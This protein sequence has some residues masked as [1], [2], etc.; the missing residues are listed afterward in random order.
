MKKRIFF[1]A[2]MAAVLVGGCCLL[3]SCEEPVSGKIVYGPTYQ[4]R[5]YWHNTFDEEVRLTW[6]ELYFHGWDE[7]R[8][9]HYVVLAPHSEANIQT[10]SLRASM[11]ISKGETMPVYGIGDVPFYVLYEQPVTDH[12]FWLVLDI[13]THTQLNIDPEKHIEI[14]RTENYRSEVVND[15]TFHFYFDIDS[16]FVASVGSGK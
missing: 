2:A 1:R 10:H 6:N 14:F 15:T 13:G 3:S 11:N 8:I 4:Y 9:Q 7:G 16:A 5:I 12:G